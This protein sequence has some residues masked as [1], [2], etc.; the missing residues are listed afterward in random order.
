MQAWYPPLAIGGEDDISAMSV[1]RQRHAIEPVA[2][3]SW[4][5]GCGHRREQRD[6]ALVALVNSEADLRSVRLLARRELAK[7]ATCAASIKFLMR[8]GPI[9][10]VAIA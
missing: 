7:R 8:L 5:R 9:L 4:R 6:E 10:A 3:R 2:W 1:N